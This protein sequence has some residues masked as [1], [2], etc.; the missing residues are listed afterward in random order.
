[1]E[2]AHPRTKETIALKSGL[3]DELQK[4]LSSVES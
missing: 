4:F 1:L 2:F 3:P